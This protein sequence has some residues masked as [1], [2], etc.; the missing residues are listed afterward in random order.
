[1]SLSVS[2]RPRDASQPSE[3]AL[4]SRV[5]KPASQLSLTPPLGPWPRPHDR[6]PRT[7]AVYD[8]L[9][10]LRMRHLHA[11]TSAAS[12]RPI[13]SAA[14]P[15][16]PNRCQP[17][18]TSHPRLRPHALTRR[19]AHAP[20]HALPPRSPSRSLALSL[21]PRCTSA[22]RRPDPACCRRPRAALC[23]RVRRPLSPAPLRS[24][25]LRSCSTPLRSTSMDP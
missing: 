9:F 25:P 24:A 20:P 1:M 4:R 12:N 10:R 5:K 7:A 8:P 15:P 22:S 19:A 17:A 14:P 23:A 13:A 21:V 2:V 6:G 11:S 18:A 16:T 3:H